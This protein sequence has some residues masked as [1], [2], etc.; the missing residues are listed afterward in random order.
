M[1]TYYS[2]HIA[3]PERSGD[4]ENKVQL[5]CCFRFVLHQ[6]KKKIL[7]SAE[8]FTASM[9]PSVSFLGGRQSLMITIFISHFKS[10]LEFK[11]SKTRPI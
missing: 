4:K 10:S 11:V 3:F 6:C 7:L 2:R 1:L 9:S 8:N 5:E